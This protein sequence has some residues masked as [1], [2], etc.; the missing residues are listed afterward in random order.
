MDN[1]R[2]NAIISEMTD[3]N[4]QRDLWRK[5]LAAVSA[6]EAAT[7]NLM[8]ALR[9]LL[10]DLEEENVVAGIVKLSD[11]LPS[12]PVTDLL[13]AAVKVLG[14]MRRENLTALNQLRQ[15]LSELATPIIRIWQDILL[16]AMI[17]N[18]DNQRAQDIA[19]KLLHRVS[20]SR[21]KV[22]LVDVTGVSMIDTAVGE[23]LIEMFS[24]IKFLGTEVIL[25]GIKP[26]VA[27]TLVK[28]GLNFR[29]VSIARDLEDALRQGIAITMEEKKRRKQLAVS[30]AGSEA[31]SEDANVEDY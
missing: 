30:L 28:L 1:T 27:H 17:G 19:E 22:V 10:E 18:I 6:G 14:Q 13:Q 24:A 5:V 21:S 4:R 26:D 7:D 2:I 16:V 23:F 12:L 31:G 11:E 8:A 29:M 9:A 20:S 3:D 25:T 15:M